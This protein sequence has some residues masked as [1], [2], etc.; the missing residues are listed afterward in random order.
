MRQSESPAPPP[1]GR[2]RREYQ[3][4]FV[5]WVVDM[6]SRALLQGI[7]LEPLTDFEL[8]WIGRM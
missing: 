1:P 8:A 7:A 2:N 3:T 4:A 6:Y 5:D